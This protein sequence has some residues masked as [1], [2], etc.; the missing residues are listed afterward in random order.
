[1]ADTRLDDFLPH[2]PRWASYAQA[3]DG[4]VVDVTPLRV[5]S[6]G[7]GGVV[8]TAADLARIYEGVFNKTLLGNA[9]GANAA[10]MSRA[11]WF[12]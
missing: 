1:M 2:G 4:S 10:F 11:N 9:H 5:D 6:G 8:S 3:P 7:D 12:V